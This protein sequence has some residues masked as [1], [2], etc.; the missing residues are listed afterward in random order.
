[1]E[2]LF[3][4]GDLIESLKRKP[5]AIY[6]DIRLGL[7]P[8]P[9]RIGRNAVRWRESDLDAWVAGLPQGVDNAINADA[10]KAKARARGDKA[11]DLEATAP[12]QSADSD[13]TEQILSR[14][15]L[16]FWS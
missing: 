12:P 15:E 8:P 16:G 14:S 1:M 3:T 2:K 7:F 11:A 9:V 5:S 13:V 6:E 4:L 10:R